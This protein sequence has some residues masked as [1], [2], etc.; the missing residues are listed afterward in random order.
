MARLSDQSI[1]PGE[2]AICPGI[3]PRE[4]REVDKGKDWM[5]NV[6]KTTYEGC[7]IILNVEPNGKDYTI[8]LLSAKDEAMTVESVL[9]FKATRLD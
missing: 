8:N 2:R 6:P 4:R 5:N 1:Y 7:H 9:H 3:M